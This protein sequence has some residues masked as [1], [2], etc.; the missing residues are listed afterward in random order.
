MPVIMPQTGHT[1]RPCVRFDVTIVDN[2]MWD[3]TMTGCA[4]HAN[5]RS[6]RRVQSVGSSSFHLRVGAPGRAGL[7]YRGFC[8]HPS[9]PR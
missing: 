7:A 9:G 4:H 3:V 1:S 6:A 2:V 5:H 8:F